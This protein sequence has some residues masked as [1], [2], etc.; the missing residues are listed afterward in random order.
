[1]NPMTSK[2]HEEI[3]GGGPPFFLSSL[4]DRG[5]CRIAGRCGEIQ[6][7]SN[8]VDAQLIG[9]RRFRK[10]QYYAKPS[11]VCTASAYT[12]PKLAHGHV[13][14]RG[15][16]SNNYHNRFCETPRCHLCGETCGESLIR[17]ASVRKPFLEF[18]HR[19]TLNG[20]TSSSRTA[21]KEQQ[22]TTTR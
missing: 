11:V 1:M 14:N 2:R 7:P 3:D 5:P 10:T 4:P 19:T 6:T 20:D 22:E 12:P 8:L 9:H 15:T 13:H 16:A 18:V 17:S 21:H